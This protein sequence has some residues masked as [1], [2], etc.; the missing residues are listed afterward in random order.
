M[1]NGILCIETATKNCSVALFED[2]HLVSCIEESSSEYIHSEKLAL[3][4]EEIL[5]DNKISAKQLSAVAVSSGP[6]SYTGLRIG[7]STAKGICVG[8]GIRLIAIPNLIQLALAAKTKDDSFELYI[9]ML[10]ARRME[11]FTAVFQSDL[12][13]LENTYAKEIDEG[14]FKDLAGKRI[15]IFGDG[16]EKCLE[17]LSDLN[18]KLVKVHCS[19]RNMGHIALTKLQDQNFED[20]AYFEP[21]YL[22]DFIAGVPKKVFK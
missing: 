9:P 15:A 8:A 11:V 13:V 21:F 3:F 18:V 4:I 5:I 17:T 1:K 16:A 7:V 22:K 14:S 10:D 12:E 2:G 20:L 19:A 6:G